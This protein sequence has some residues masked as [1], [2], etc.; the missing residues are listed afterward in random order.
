MSEPTRGP[1]EL[2]PSGIIA[3]ADGSTVRFIALIQAHGEGR[4]MDAEDVA[5]GG[6]LAASWELREACQ[7]A[8]SLNEGTHTGVTPEHVNGMLRAAIAK[9][10]GGNDA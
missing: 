8:L 5:T 9:A 7:A 2:R 10:T 6:L 3:T 4:Y 1:Y